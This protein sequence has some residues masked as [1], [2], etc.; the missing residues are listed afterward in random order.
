MKKIIRFL[1]W[2]GA[3]I[4]L[5]AFA[6][7]LDAQTFQKQQGETYHIYWL[8]AYEKDGELIPY[9]EVIEFI[10]SEYTENGVTEIQVQ[11]TLSN[12]YVCVQDASYWVQSVDQNNNKSSNSDTVYVKMTGETIPPETEDIPVQ[13]RVFAMLDWTGNLQQVDGI[14][15]LDPLNFVSKSFSVIGGVYRVEIYFVGEIDLSFGAESYNLFNDN[16][17]QPVVQEFN[18]DAGERLLHILAIERTQFRYGEEDWI[19]RITKV[20]PSV[21]LY[22][23]ASIWVQ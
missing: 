6:K 23:P 18:L 7:Q 22:P 21:E 14:G 15:T 9:E 2:L 17:F 16:R 1:V 3:T 5:I 19:L 8:N 12:P 10:V 13:F 20:E 11:D 4:A